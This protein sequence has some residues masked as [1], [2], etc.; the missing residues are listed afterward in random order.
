MTGPA[1]FPYRWQLDMNWTH[2]GQQPDSNRIGTGH[3][4]HQASSGMPLD[5]TGR[6][7]ESTGR[8]SEST[9]CPLESSW[10]IGRPIGNLGEGEVL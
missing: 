10:S 2:N 6:P 3:P 8:P 7:S 4:V 1:S 5:S 9:G